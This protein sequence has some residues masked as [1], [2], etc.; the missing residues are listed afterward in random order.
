MKFFAIIFHYKMYV[1][2]WCFNER[3]YFFSKA[4]LCY[5]KAFEL[6]N[7]DTEVGM[8]Y[9]KLLKE[10]SKE[11]NFIC[12]T[13]FM[14]KCM[15]IYFN[16][17]KETICHIYNYILLF[18]VLISGRK[19]E[20]FENYHWKCWFGKVL[21]KFINNTTFPCCLVLAY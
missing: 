10:M 8:C 21:F 6:D 15:L 20:S 4:C 3:K 17:L 14:Y 7:S 18:F 1:L 12:P 13:L 11:V 19:Y 16:N 5:Q 9:S 2:N